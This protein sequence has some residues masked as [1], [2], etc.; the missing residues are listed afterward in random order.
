[1]KT[2]K[3]E[4]EIQGTD[5]EKDETFV[6]ERGLRR[7]TEADLNETLKQ[8]QNNLS[9]GKMKVEQ[10]QKWIDE[11]GWEEDLELQKSN[12]GIQEAF[13]K[14]LETAAKPFY[15]KKEAEG[16]KLAAKKKLAEHYDRADK[17]K[18]HDL[19]AKILNEVRHE[20]GYDDIHHPVILAIGKKFDEVK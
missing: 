6:V 13:I 17:R 10:L 4:F 8:A 19:R 1:M 9:Q 20:L 14:A 5:T 7:Y 15:D 12:I 3:W 16:T 18:K 2:V 11:K